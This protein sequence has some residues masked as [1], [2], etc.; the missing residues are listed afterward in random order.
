MGLL[1]PFFICGAGAPAGNMITDTD[2][3]VID[4]K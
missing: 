2:G 3:G 1:Q 4:M